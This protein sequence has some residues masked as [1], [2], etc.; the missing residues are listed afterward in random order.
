[1]SETIKTWLNVLRDDWRLL[2]FRLTREEFLAFNYKHLVFGFVFTW[3]VGIGRYWDNPRV[4][5]LQKLGIGS[6]IYICLLSL[7]LLILILPLKAKNWSYTRVLTFVSLVSPPAILYAIPV[8]KFTS[9]KTSNT[10]NARFLLVVALWRVALLIF[11]LRRFFS[12]DWLSTITATF[13]PI[14][15]IIVSLVFLNL[16][17]VVFNFMGGFRDESPNDAAYG[18]L[19]IISVFSIILFP[20]FLISYIVLIVKARSQSGSIKDESE[21]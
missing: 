19:F 13:L 17:R 3:L 4:E 2:T 15:L 16:E 18:V 14:I 1:M 6:V 12:M 20:V 21:N 8:E 9:L 11:A 5:F 7:F 10:L